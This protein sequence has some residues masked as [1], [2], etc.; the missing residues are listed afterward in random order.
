MSKE[1]GLLEMS[2]PDTRCSQTLETLLSLVAMSVSRM[3]QLEKV[4]EA[5]IALGDAR[6]EV[7]RSIISWPDK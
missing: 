1:A 4:I 3:R 5:A 6:T 7:R 2:V